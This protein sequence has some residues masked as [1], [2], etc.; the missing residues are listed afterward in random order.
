MSIY[1]NMVGTY[2]TLGK[3]FIIED[4]N[5]NEIVGV[6]TAN[7]QVFDATPEDV[8]LGKTFAYDGG[9][10]VGTDT[11]MAVAS[12]CIIAPSA[13]LT[14]PLS[15]YD[16]Y[17]Y[18]KFQC[19]IFVRNNPANIIGYTVDDSVFLI[20]SSTQVATVSKNA[21]THSVDLNINNDS[22]QEYEIRYFT[23]RE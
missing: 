11:K 17:D 6:I 5:G 10:G 13:P 21:D 20:G 12:S 19:V 15:E 9:V 2:S 8:K 23:Y 18:T 7:E 14:I 3:T 16:A 1:G 4:D 22:T